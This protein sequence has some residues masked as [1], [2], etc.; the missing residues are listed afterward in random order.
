MSKKAL[1]M[2]LDG[3]GL[4]DGKKDDVISN[5]PT[6]YWDYL[7]KTYPNSQ[8][9]ASGENVGLPDGQMGNS[10]VGHLNIGAGRVV[11]QD[12]VKINRACADNSILKNPGIVSAFSYAK[13]KGKSVHFMGL[14]SD[15]GVHSSLDHLFKLC[16]IAKEYGIDNTFIHCFMDGRDT[17]PKRGKGFIEELSAHCDKSAGKIASII[18]R[19]YAMDRDKRW[20]RVKEAYDLLVNGIGKKATDMAQ[21]MQESYDEGVTDE[22]IKPIVNAGFDGTIKEGD[23]VIFFNYRNDRAKEL[24]VVLTQQD[25]PDAGMRIVPGLQ[26]YCMTP[27]DASFKGLHVL[28]DK[29]N[30]DNTLGEY[31]SSKGLKQLHIAE[32]EK[33]AHVTFFFN[34]GRETPYEGEDRI[35]VPSPKV[36]T[37]DLKPEM[38]AYEVKDKLVAAI[39]ENKYDFIVVN[40][41]NGDMVGHTGVYEAIEKAVIA[42]DA[43]VKD[44]IE[45]AKAQDYE[46]IIIADHGNADHA[47]NE[48]GTP[49]TAHSLNPVPCIYVTEAN[50]GAKVANGRLADVAPTILKIMGLPVPA[51]MSGKVLIG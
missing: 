8:L 9:Q 16:D 26:Y 12:L 44:V 27:Y 32:T 43:C 42:V 2:I 50:K 19:Y 31:L 46:A 28:F 14:T 33:Y 4:G 10:E 5:T 23:V 22:F 30:V 36:A 7:M 29:E 25:M 13:E 45:A 1:L 38:S 35:L 37:Y 20:E 18:G 47:L 51:E 34:G 49:N 40:F 39:N 48:D 3:W 24:T 41:A 15:G 6:P 21:A 11:Y 17:D